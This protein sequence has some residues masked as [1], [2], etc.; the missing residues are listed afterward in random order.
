M[1]FGDSGPAGGRG[2]QTTVKMDNALTVAL[3]NERCLDVGERG[4]LYG[5][6][7]PKTGTQSHRPSVLFT[8][9]VGLPGT[10]VTAAF[11]CRCA[12]KLGSLPATKGET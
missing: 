4:F 6:T 8:K 3:L 2:V 5:Q 1:G 9:A 7:R 11:A 10:A 12:G